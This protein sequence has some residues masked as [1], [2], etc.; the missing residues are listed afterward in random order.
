VATADLEGTIRRID[1][2]LSCEMTDTEVIVMLA[3][4]A[5]AAAVGSLVSHLVAESGSGRVIRILSVAPAAAAATRSSWALAGWALAGVLAITAAA[6][7]VALTNDDGGG[8]T[9]AI[10]DRRSTTTTSAVRRTSSTTLATTTTVSVT[11]TTSTTAAP[12]TTAAAPTTTT[13]TTA[14]RPAFAVERS[15]CRQDDRTLT[16][17]GSVVNRSGSTHSYRVTVRFLD[18]ARRP[19]ATGRTDVPQVRPREQ[20]AWIVQTTYDGDLVTSGGSCQ[21]S[22]SVIG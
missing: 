3:E 14:P 11:T 7:V 22:A 17:R 4:G 1:G 12:A 18:R 20:R 2:V 8:S 13:S 21:V 5:K 9:S 19:V 6:L 16:S 10:S 15:E